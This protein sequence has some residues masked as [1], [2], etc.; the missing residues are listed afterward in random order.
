MP[1]RSE[2]GKPQAEAAPQQL[3]TPRLALRLPAPRAR[4]LVVVLVV[5]RQPRPGRCCL[6]EAPA[7]LREAEPGVVPEAAEPVAPAAPEVLE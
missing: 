6:P 3:L 1:I 7:E 5:Q 2:L 4:V